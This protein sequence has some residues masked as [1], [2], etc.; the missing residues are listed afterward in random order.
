MILSASV[1]ELPFVGEKYA[2]KLKKLN[3]TTLGDLLEHIPSRYVD[4]RT[5]GKIGKL[6]PGEHTTIVG[7]VISCNS[8]YTKTGK[9]LQLAKVSDGECQL[10]VVWMNMPYIVR[11]LKPGVFVSLSGKVSFWNKK[12]SLTFPEFEVLSDNR[13]TVHTGKIVPIYPETSGVSSKWLRSK[14]IYLLEKLNPNDV[15]EYLPPIQDLNFVS[16]FEAFRCVHTP[17]E[18]MEAARG[19]DR[20]AFDELLELQVANN[21]DKIAW[22]AKNSAHKIVSDKHKLDK[23]INKLKY[24]LT[25][26]QSRSLGEILNDL[27]KVTPMNRLLEGDVGSGK[28]VVAALA[29]YSVYTNGYKTIFMA[30]TQILAQ[31]HFMAL[32]SILGGTGIKISLVTA[33]VKTHAEADIYVGTH[34]LLY[35]A[36]A[37]DTALIVIDEQHRFGVKQRAKLASEM[38]SDKLPHTLTMTATPIPRSVALS[39]YG[40]LDL[41]TLD[42][43]PK[44]R[45]KITTWIV[46]PEKRDKGYE[47]IDQE[48]SKN[49]IQVYVV[50]PLIDESESEML[51]QVRAV[52]AEYESLTNVF[53]QRRIGLLHGRLSAKDK[54]RVLETFASGEIDILVSTPVIE[55][56]ID[57]ANATIMVI[58]AAERFGLSQLH[59]LRGRV[60]RGNKQSYCLLMTESKASKTKNRL[61]ALRHAKN[62]MELAEIDLSMRGPGHIFGI[63]QHGE[64]ELKFASWSDIALM[65]K[66]KQVAHDVIKN[67]GK[68]AK[69][70]THYKTKQVAGN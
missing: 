18:P 7:Q 23:V 57:I 11:A 47:W 14:M 68:Y 22:E 17:R 24:T 70:L 5:V 56:G 35:R 46:P 55:V 10:D 26:S 41:S 42:E 8:V 54:T 6:K 19:R 15:P 67:Q 49:K 37:P 66:A 3:I 31:Q 59:Q 51:T 27:N 2:S 69:L 38:T 20:L 12:L 44:G 13:E 36:S 64:T 45:K 65:K 52:K 61:D 21:L 25:K 33:G 48:I 43:M 58:E 40:D 62:G 63:R 32:S 34:A 29:A 53:P 60:G 16:R 30:P 9:R 50:C 4:Y 28:T 39:F 1:T